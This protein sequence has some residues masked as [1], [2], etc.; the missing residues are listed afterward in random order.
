MEQKEIKHNRVLFKIKLN[1][2]MLYKERLFK[3]IE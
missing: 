1:K 2:I 3:Q